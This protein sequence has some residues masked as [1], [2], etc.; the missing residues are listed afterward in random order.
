MA[1]R[2]QMIGSLFSSLIFLMSLLNFV[3]ILLLFYG[4]AFCFQARGILVPCPGIEPRA[5]CIQKCSLNH[6]TA[7]EVPGSLF[8]ITLLAPYTILLAGSFVFILL[9]LSSDHL[10]GWQIDPIR[11]ESMAG[12]YTCIMSCGYYLSLREIIFSEVIS[13]LLC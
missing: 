1:Q 10:V 5:P 8:Y 13:A 9:L 2:K 3:T 7:R 6:W 12:L 4:L 11:Q